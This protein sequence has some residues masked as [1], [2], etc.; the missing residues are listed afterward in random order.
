MGKDN[1]LFYAG[2]K[3]EEA[4]FHYAS[5]PVA[6]PPP[7]PLPPP[8]AVSH[9]H[10]FFTKSVMALVLISTVFMFVSLYI[11]FVR[12]YRRRSPHRRAM[13]QQQQPPPPAMDQFL[14]GEEPINYIWYINTVGLDESLINS[15]TSC[16]FK[17]GEGLVEE[18][19]CSVCLSEFEDGDDLRLLPKCS[20][21]FHLQC[22]DRWLRAHVNCPLCRAPVFANN[23]NSVS[24]DNIATGPSSM[25]ASYDLESADSNGD[26]SRNSDSLAVEIGESGLE[27]ETVMTNLDVLGVLG[28]QSSG[29][30]QNGMT[31]D[32]T[33]EFQPV[34]RS[35]SLNS[36]ARM[37][38]PAVLATSSAREFSDLPCGS[39]V[40]AGSS[41]RGNLN[42]GG[43]SRFR[44]VPFEKRGDKS[45]REVDREPC[46]QK[47]PS[48]MRR[49]FSIGTNFFF[50]KHGRNRSFVLPL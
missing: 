43:F 34:R 36:L 26:L 39:V 21:A 1:P 30:E 48:C 47:G 22:I 38:A 49:S 17:S 8:P 28:G 5:P 31:V 11:T 32:E 50:S 46:P 16:K 25:D 9:H 14:E 20:H 35:V 24:G 23:L 29:G 42:L 44:E 15:I 2:C 3:E 19:G 6:S 7:P 33:T 45:E 12:W 41:D 18:T 13:Q 27:N 10:L 37:H 40:E 4:S